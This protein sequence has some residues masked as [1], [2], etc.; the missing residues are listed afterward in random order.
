M[1]NPIARCKLKELERPEFRRYSAATMNTRR[2]SP[3]I[4]PAGFEDVQAIF[5]LIK[6]HPRELLPRPISDIVQ[7]VDRFLVCELGGKVAGV[8]SWQILPEIGAPRNP[9]VEIKSL[10]VDGD[11]QRAGLGRALVAAAIER[12]RQ[13]HPIQVLALTFQPA[14]FRK[15]GFEEVPKE[16]LMHKIYAG[17]INCTKY[18]SP[19]T[20]P[21]VAMALTVRPRLEPARKK[22]AR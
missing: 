15:L 19:F 2:K 8:V 22:P 3:R 12:V 6:R 20:C 10:A 17:C 14:F 4:R 7:N 5:D 13:L 18:D 16:S 21:E 11:H 1:T 9:S